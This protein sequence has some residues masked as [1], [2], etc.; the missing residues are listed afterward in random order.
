MSR[1]VIV[2]GASSGSQ[3]PAFTT[4]NV[5]LFLA[6]NLHCI[7]RNDDLRCVRGNCVDCRTH[8]R[9]TLCAQ[10]LRTHLAEACILHDDHTMSEC[11]MIQTCA[12]PLCRCIVVKQHSHHSF[13]T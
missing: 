8:K 6:T 11:L 4:R 7:A 3:W 13:V 2:Y 10:N 9:G 5:Y 1:L 12:Q